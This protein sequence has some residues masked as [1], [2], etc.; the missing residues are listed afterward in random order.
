MLVRL[1]HDEKVVLKWWIEVVESIAHKFNGIPNET[2]VDLSYLVL[3]PSQFLVWKERLVA[4]TR[5]LAHDINEAW[6]QPAE[7]AAVVIALFITLDTAT[8]IISLC[9]RGSSANYDRKLLWWQCRLPVVI[10]YSVFATIVQRRFVDHVLKYEMTIA[11][12][13]A[14]A[15]FLAGSMLH[16]CRRGRIKSD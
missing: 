9:L 14:G 3:P 2:R 13:C 4:F 11:W 10:V 5:T 6:D 8:W 15:L 7:F 1:R 16:S 12:I